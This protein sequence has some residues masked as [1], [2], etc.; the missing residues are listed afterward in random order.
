ME[1]TMLMDEKMM[2][3]IP[4][5]YKESSNM[6]LKLLIK[7]A[8]SMPSYDNIKK[9]HYT[10]VYKESITNGTGTLLMESD[11]EKF[12]AEY[13]RMKKIGKSLIVIVSLTKYRK[14]N[15][16]EWK[17]KKKV[18]L[19]ESE[20]SSSTLS[21]DILVPLRKKIKM[22]KVI[23][24]DKNEIC[25]A[26]TII[27]LHKK[28]H[29]TWHNQPCLVENHHHF[30][31]TPLHIKLWAHDILYRESI[32]ILLTLSL[33]D[34]NSSKELSAPIPRPIQQSYLPPPLL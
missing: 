6:K 13:Q 24:L 26:K 5:S 11:F 20:S 33:F 1:E 9:K 18:K 7:S 22:P 21:S 16:R 31:L 2:Q 4:S 27:V 25:I 17:K 19:K 3:Q 29:C 10:I 14:E 12:L 34:M 28:Y 15:N 23:D 32:E 8:L 30:R